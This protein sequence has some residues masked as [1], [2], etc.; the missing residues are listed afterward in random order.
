MAKNSP[1]SVEAS[2]RRVN[3]RERTPLH[4][5]LADV[6]WKKT[7]PPYLPVYVDYGHGWAPWCSRTM[8]VFTSIRRQKVGT[9]FFV[10]LAA[11]FLTRGKNNNKQT[12]NSHAS[13]GSSD[14]H[15]LCSLTHSAQTRNFLN[16]IIG[17]HHHHHDHHHEFRLDFRIPAPDR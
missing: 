8:G 10:V 1:N 17:H 11:N 7:T 9:W 3:F 6:F 4:A 16:L 2:V 15:V 13:T 12:M 5:S 14:V